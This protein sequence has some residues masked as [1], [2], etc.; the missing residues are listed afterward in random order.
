MKKLSILVFA[1]TLALLTT[2]CSN[3]NPILTDNSKNT[4]KISSSALLF[5][6]NDTK[7]LEKNLSNTVLDITKEAYN[8]IISSTDSDYIIGFIKIEDGEAYYEQK[9]YINSEKGIIN[10]SDIL[11][12]SNLKYTVINVNVPLSTEPTIPSIITGGCPY[13]S[14]EWGTC[15]QNNP[16]YS[17]GDCLSATM[18]SLAA[19]Y[20]SNNNSILMFSV[21]NGGLTSICYKTH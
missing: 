14:S 16:D 9:H 10:Y 20:T 7:E 5:T 21:D 18:G 19:T 1:L 3:D 4:Q 15:E 12:Y 17:Y 13:G 2:Y 8:E 6:F 11:D